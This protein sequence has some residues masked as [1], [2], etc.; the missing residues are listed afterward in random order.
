MIYKY[1]TEDKIN[2]VLTKKVIFLTIFQKK[3]FIN[4]IIFYSAVVWSY[5]NSRHLFTK[6]F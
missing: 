1:L 5:Y 6:T 4:I 2:Q 3:Y